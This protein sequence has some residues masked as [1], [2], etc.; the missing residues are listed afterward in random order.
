MSSA[1]YKRLNGRG[2]SPLKNFVNDENKPIAKE[3]KD[4]QFF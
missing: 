3:A 1:R 4:T 2:L